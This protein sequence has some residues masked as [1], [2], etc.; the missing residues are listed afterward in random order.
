MKRLMLL[1][2]ALTATMISACAPSTSVEYDLPP[3]NLP[4][5]PWQSTAFANRTLDVR[6]YPASI[7]VRQEERGRVSLTEFESSADYP[8]IYTYIHDQ[9][10]EAGW[11]RVSYEEKGPEEIEARFVQGDETLT[12]YLNREG[13]SGRYTIEFGD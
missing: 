5:P 10:I 8:T 1:L 2:L 7:V 13:D 9:L 3:Q 12:L 11:R 4:P 6:L